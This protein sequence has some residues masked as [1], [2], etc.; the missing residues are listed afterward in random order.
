MR[1][2]IKTSNI[3]KFQTASKQF[4]SDLLISNRSLHLIQKILQLLAF[5][6]LKLIFSYKLLLYEIVISPEF[7]LVILIVAV[8]F[9]FLVCCLALLIAGEIRHLDK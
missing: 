2:L 4:S 8:L 5:L 9:L 3:S 6:Y 1:N 7:G